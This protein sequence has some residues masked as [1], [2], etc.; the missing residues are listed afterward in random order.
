MLTSGFLHI[1]WMHLLINMFVLFSF[2]SGLEAA[3]GWIL[4]LAIYFISMVG[5]NLLALIIHKHHPFYTSVGASG[6]ISGLVFATIT[7]MPQMKIFFIPGWVFGVLYVIYALYAIRSERRDV[8]HAAHLG[9]GLVG[10]AL[11]ILFFPGTILENWIPV[12]C[13]FIPAVTLL[14]IMIYR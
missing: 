3:I 4:F 14:L 8:G 9:G 10:M 11:A 1:S 7:L 5:G 6:A 13:I 2:G 12:V